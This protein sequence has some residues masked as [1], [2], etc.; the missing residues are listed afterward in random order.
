MAA[1]PKDG[2][3]A[4]VLRAAAEGN[5]PL[6]GVRALEKATKTS[7]LSK[8]QTTTNNG[9][10]AA[11]TQLGDSRL[12]IDL[13]W[14]AYGGM[15]YQFAGIA[16]TRNFET[17]RPV[18]QTTVESFRPLSANERESIREKRLRLV[19]AKAGETVK[20][21]TARTGSA[22]KADQV[23]VA[24]GLEESATLREGQLIKITI[25]EPYAGKKQ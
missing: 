8:T 3:T 13:T 25:E 19:K 5:D 4:V 24:N 12:T 18:F 9:L 16:E 14:L 23:A 10:P 11:K 21:L 17:V 15:I 7:L 1:A 2:G 6:D 20:A 22:W